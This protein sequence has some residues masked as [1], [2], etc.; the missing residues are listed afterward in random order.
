MKK[1]RKDPSWPSSAENFLWS[2]GA[3]LLEGLL[4]SLQGLSVE[5]IS[6]ISR[7]AFSF[8]TCSLHQLSAKYQSP[9]PPEIRQ[10][11][12]GKQRGRR[13]SFL[14]VCRRAHAH[15]FLGD[16]KPSCCCWVITT[17]AHAA[18]FPRF[19]YSR[20]IHLIPRLALPSQNGNFTVSFDLVVC[21]ISD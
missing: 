5:I 10:P 4:L 18:A 3:A 11:G 13:C 12:A 20:L 8:L 15:M 17:K 2:L 19:L 1:L 21:K 14:L 7:V 16:G 6:A 9:P